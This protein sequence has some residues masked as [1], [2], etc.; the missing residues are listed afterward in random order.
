M[1]CEDKPIWKDIDGFDGA[2]QVNQYGEVRSFKNGRHGTRDEVKLLTIRKWTNKTDNNIRW[3]VSL[4]SSTRPN[5]NYY[6]HRLV[7]ETFILNTRKVSD[8]DHID[9]NPS[10]NHVSNIRWVSKRENHHNMKR[11]YNNISGHK[12]VRFRED[13]NRWT[14][15][16]EENGRT[17]F[18]MFKTIEEAIDHRCKMVELH[19]SKEHYIED[20]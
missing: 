10:N 11:Q 2:Y 3:N 4:S 8:V 9:G 17:K 5:K 13:R 19:Y 15:N 14:A 7:A 18:K 6:I 1:M 12:G 20:R 16:W